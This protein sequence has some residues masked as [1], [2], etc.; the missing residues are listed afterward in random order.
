[1]FFFSLYGGCCNSSFLGWW[2]IAYISQS[3]LVL[4]RKSSWKKFLLRFVSFTLILKRH[5]FLFPHCSSFECFKKNSSLHAFS[6]KQEA[7]SLCAYWEKWHLCPAGSTITVSSDHPDAWLVW[8]VQSCLFLYNRRVFSRQAWSLQ[9]Y[10]IT[11]SQSSL[12]G[13]SLCKI[14]CPSVAAGTSARNTGPVLKITEDWG[15]TGPSDA[16]LSSLCWV[17]ICSPGIARRPQV[18]CGCSMEERFVFKLYDPSLNSAKKGRSAMM[19]K[20][21]KRHEGDRDPSLKDLSN[22]VSYAEKNMMLIT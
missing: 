3:S 1:M 19:I 13:N 2:T 14:F 21:I 18:H 5:Q 20:K 4:F 22:K 16:A 7:K 11:Q 10:Q 8:S 9:T 6:C 17:S 15:S 12:N